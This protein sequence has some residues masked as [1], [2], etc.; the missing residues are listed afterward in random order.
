MKAKM[1]GRKFG[2]GENKVDPF[3]LSIAGGVGIA[4]TSLP[5]NWRLD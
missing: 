2:A 1:S 4:E 3:D 5:K